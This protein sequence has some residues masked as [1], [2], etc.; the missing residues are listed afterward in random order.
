MSEQIWIV[1]RQR[2]EDY[3]AAKH[4]VSWHPS[5]AEAESMAA[6]L[7]RE[8]DQARERTTPWHIDIETIFDMKRQHTHLTERELEEHEAAFI[9]QLNDW[10][11]KERSAWQAFAEDE[12]M[13]KMTDPPSFCLHLV[14]DEAVSYVCYAVGRGRP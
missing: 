13:A 3:G 6:R 11:H 14:R 4:V 7:Q 12:V 1:E 10:W 5:L 8:F 9:E 2:D